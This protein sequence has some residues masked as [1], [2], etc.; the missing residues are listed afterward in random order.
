MTNDVVLGKH[1]I[2]LAGATKDFVLE[3]LDDVSVDDFKGA[4]HIRNGVRGSVP[5]PLAGDE[6]KFLRGDG[7]WGYA[8]LTKTVGAKLDSVPNYENGGMW[9]EV[10]GGVP[11][12][13]LFAE[14]TTFFFNT[15]LAGE[16]PFDPRLSLSRVYDSRP[17]DT[18]VVKLNYFGNGAPSFA[19]SSN[20]VE[21]LY[22]VDDH[23]LILTRT[24]GEI[25][26][27][28]T[29]NVEIAETHLF[30][31]SAASVALEFDVPTPI[32]RDPE[33]ELIQIYDT[34]LP[35]DSKQ[36]KLS[37]RGNVTPWLEVDN[38]DVEIEYDIN[39]REVTLTR[40]YSGE[41]TTCR[42]SVELAESSR[43]DEAGAYVDLVFDA[44]EELA[45]PNLTLSKYELAG[46]ANED[47]CVG[48]DYLGNGRVT[49]S[50]TNPKIVPTYDAKARVLTISFG[51][52][53]TGFDTGKIFAVLSANE[54]YQ[55]TDGRIGESGEVIV[56]LNACDDY[57]QATATI[58]C[59]AIDEE[60]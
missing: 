48:V 39:E 3:Q 30:S 14:D 53:Y 27:T 9:Y 24:S 46:V 33:L 37:Y 41:Y 10:E 1:I 13:K 29:A 52:V 5:Q 54:N 49:V 42:L 12:V 19:L 36:I 6:K 4:T 57:T 18:Q 32:S 8:P 47:Y 55:A 28:L 22:D 15:E 31:A 51:N 40:K 25:P 43:Y 38:D 59:Y 50:T 34:K 16:P 56:T 21:L 2:S 23:E 11:V 45:E 7:S 58:H 60:D 26:I 44:A 35:N 17:S 20:E